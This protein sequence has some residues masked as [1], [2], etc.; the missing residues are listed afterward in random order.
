M[1][2]VETR[3]DECAIC[4]QSFPI[5]QLLKDRSRPGGY[6]RR[7]RTCHAA[8]RRQLYKSG[9]TARYRKENCDI[10]TV[11]IA[12][13]RAAAYGI[14]DRITLAQWREVVAEFGKKCLACGSTARIGIDHV[15]PF[16]EGGGNERAN[17]QPLCVRCNRA[18]GV[19]TIDYRPNRPALEAAPF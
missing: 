14:G 13:D 4:K 1:P 8:R 9:E 19:K 2:A 7:C 18:K 16:V 15:V 6:K 12:N 10:F 17:L 3:Q 5:D 11:S